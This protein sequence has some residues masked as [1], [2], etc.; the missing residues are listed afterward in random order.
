MTL[1]DVLAGV[2]SKL[3]PLVGNRATTFMFPQRAGG[4]NWPAIRVTP[5]T[6]TG[7]ASI[8]G[9]AGDEGADIRLQ[10]DVVTDYTAGESAHGALRA[11]VMS[12]MKE[13]GPTYIWDGQ[14]SMFDE[15]T[16]TFRTSLDYMVY[17]STTTT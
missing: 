11:K 5:I 12:A 14:Q 6:I 9:D 1:A 17:L 2:M 10:I 8:D 15:P 13:L 4:G 3:R 16:R 7:E